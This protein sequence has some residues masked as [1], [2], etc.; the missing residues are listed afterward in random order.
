MLATLMD[1]GATLI[2]HLEGLSS[3][4]TFP[5]FSDKRFVNTLE[6]HHPE[7]RGAD[8]LISDSAG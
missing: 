2:L 7:N 3:G 6:G 5:L 8:K 1:C 4:D